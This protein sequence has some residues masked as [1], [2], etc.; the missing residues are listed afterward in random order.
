[1]PTHIAHIA[2]ALRPVPNLLREAKA[3]TKVLAKSAILLSPKSKDY[4]IHIGSQEV[5]SKNKL[6]K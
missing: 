6:F 4:L 2:I 3:E 5:L 1:M